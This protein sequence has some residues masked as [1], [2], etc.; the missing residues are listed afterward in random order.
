MSRDELNKLSKG[1]LVE[2]VLE[3]SRGKAEI[4][5]NPRK[6]KG[7]SRMCADLTLAGDILSYQP[8]VSL[9]DGLRLTLEKGSGFK[10]TPTE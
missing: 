6:D 2:L 7:V 5:Y 8:R 4:V 3:I 9:E 1:E 10:K